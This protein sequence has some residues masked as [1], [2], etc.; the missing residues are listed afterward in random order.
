MIH[1]GLGIPGN[2]PF[3]MTLSAARVDTRI[4]TVATTSKYDI[5]DKELFINKFTVL[6]KDFRS[7]AKRKIAGIAGYVKIF[8]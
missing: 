2:E 1:D 7:Y 6:A 4:R 8:R 3:E 5:I